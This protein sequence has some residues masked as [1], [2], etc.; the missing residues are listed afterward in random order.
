M[1]GIA[2]AEVFGSLAAL[3][4]DA[5][6]LL[7]QAPGLFEGMRWWQV[8]VG[9]AMPE[10]A[11]PAFVVIS[12]AGRIAAVLPM[13]RDP[14]PGGLS[15]L[16]T[17][18]SCEYRPLFAAGLDHTAR[19]GAMSAFARFCREFGAVRLDALPAEWD[20]IGDLTAGARSA[21][22]QV[23]RFDHFGNWCE[24]VAGV[25]W[26]AYLLARPGALRET[27]G[28][29]LRRAEKL[30]DARFELLADAAEMDRAA[31]A[32]EAVYRRSWKEPEPFPNFNVALMRSMAE[33]GLLRFG[34]WSLATQPVAVQLW[35]VH[36]G[37]AYVLKLAH[38]E[39]F[40]V[41][42]PGTVLTALMLRHML[43]E[44]HVVRID[45]GRGDDAY[46]QG[47]AN[48]RRQRIGVVLVNPWR[49]TGAAEL[50]RHVAGRVRAA[51]G[52]WSFRHA[53]PILSNVDPR[54]SRGDQ[55]GPAEAQFCQWKLPARLCL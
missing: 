9:H 32:F 7:D 10:G 14:R 12:E 55:N 28:R 23:L 1:R 26:P 2:C 33:A 4:P 13:R 45:F 20:G 3:P 16:T 5:S 39:A 50:L 19:V 44:E 52:G 34:L 31:E 54:S 48:T 21:G 42:S 46:K 11:E 24:D 51:A 37:C 41:H 25:E 53:R 18:Y 38:D 8:V 30:G 17:P 29:R 22:L 43:D 49:T 35:V 6:A 15:S 27:I 47:W 36:G 40:K